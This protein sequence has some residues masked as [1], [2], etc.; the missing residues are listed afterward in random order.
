MQ[1][2]FDLNDP[3]CESKAEEGRSQNME[4]DEVWLNFGV[5]FE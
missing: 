5:F 4:K 2:N 1:F 3:L